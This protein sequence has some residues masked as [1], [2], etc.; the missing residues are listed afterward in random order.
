MVLLQNSPHPELSS[1]HKKIKN[2]KEFKIENRHRKEGIRI[3]LRRRAKILS[4]VSSRKIIVSKMG[5]QSIMSQ[6]LSN[7][8]RGWCSSIQ[9]KCKCRIHQNLNISMDKM[10]R[11]SR[12][13][14]LFKLI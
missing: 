10:G 13:H 5:N 11:M 2:L 4:K 8:V 12:M 14:K 6:T 1:P 9:N 7:P 3:R